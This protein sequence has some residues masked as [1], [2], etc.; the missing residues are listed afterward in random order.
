V[1]IQPP[2]LADLGHAPEG[3]CSRWMKGSPCGGAG[4]HHVIW[5]SE[6]TNGCVC[7]SHTAEVRENWVYIGLHRYTAACAA[8][9]L[10]VWLVSEDRCVLPAD[11]REEV[12]HAVAVC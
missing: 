12:R 9:G 8:P 10:A 7:A 4:M 1:S 2:I 5:D 3:V 11:E 6:M